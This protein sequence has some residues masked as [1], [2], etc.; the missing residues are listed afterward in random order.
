MAQVLVMDN[1]ERVR[2]ELQR[3]IS[4]STATSNFPD[5][6]T[7]IKSDSGIVILV[8]EILDVTQNRMEL[9]DVIEATRARPEYLP[10]V[11]FTNESTP[12][13]IGAVF[14]GY[15]WHSFKIIWCSSK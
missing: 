4:E 2:R 3:C 8:T 9:K 13:K 5:A 1:G 14:I 12:Q 11:I 15:R 10:V 7:A 6:L